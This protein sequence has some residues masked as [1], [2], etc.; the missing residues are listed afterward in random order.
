MGK[1]VKKLGHRI[2]V[3]EPKK[4]DA[5]VTITRQIDA[6]G[7]STVGIRIE[8]V[9]SGCLVADL[10]M[11]M[12]DFAGAV[13]AMGN[14]PARL[15]L[16]DSLDRLGKKGETKTAEV[17]CKHGQLPSPKDLKALEVEGWIVQE[18]TEFNQHRFSS[19][20]VPD[21][22]RIGHTERGLGSYRVTLHRWVEQ[23]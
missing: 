20:R 9:L 14:Q 2:G 22:A 12:T 11:S 21:V 16:Y 4:L 17:P 23:W 1:P 19:G 5:Q 3:K 8:E 15:V 7:D 10:T 13:F 18:E 6:K